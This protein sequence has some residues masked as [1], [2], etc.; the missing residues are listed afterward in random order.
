MSYS[1][2]L[3]DLH[4]TYSWEDEAECILESYYNPFDFKTTLTARVCLCVC[5]CLTGMS[6]SF[7]VILINAHILKLKQH[8]CIAVAQGAVK[9]GRHVFLCNEL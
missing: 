5:V 9:A 7:G 8:I 3:S 6:L 1:C 4:I 2:S